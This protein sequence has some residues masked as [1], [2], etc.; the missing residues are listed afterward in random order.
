[1]TILLLFGCIV[2]CL[3]NIYYIINILYISYIDIGAERLSEEGDVVNYLWNINNK[4][5]TSQVLICTM[6][7]IS[8]KL[9]GEGINALIIYH[10]PQA[11]RHIIALEI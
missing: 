11:V 3:S 10:D 9:L 5:Y 6:E 8:Q 7:S 2:T 4:Y 1:M